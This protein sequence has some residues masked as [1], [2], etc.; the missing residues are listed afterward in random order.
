MSQIH[1][2][3]PRTRSEPLLELNS[4]LNASHGQRHLHE[5]TR[6]M[7]VLVLFHFIAAITIHL[8]AMNKVSNLVLLIWQ[9]TVLLSGGNFLYIFLNW[10]SGN[11]KTQIIQLP[12][13]QIFIASVFLAVVWSVPLI[14][15]SR[16]IFDDSNII[17]FGIVMAM[18]AMGIVTMLRVPMSAIAYISFLSVVIS[19]YLFSTLHEHKMLGTVICLIAGVALV[20][21]IIVLHNDVKHTAQIEAANRR[22]N[23]TIKLLLNDFEQETKDWIW[24]IDQHFMLTSHSP[25]LTSIFELTPDALLKDNFLSVLATIAEKTDVAKLSDEIAK[26]CNIV[27]FILETNQNNI[28]LYWKISARAKF[29]LEDNFLGYDGVSRDITEQHKSEIEIRAAKD[30][31]ERASMA[32][33]QFLAV[34]SHELRTPINSIVGFS[35]ILNAGQN[36][37]ISAANRKAY[38]DTILD[39]SKQ[40]QALINDILDATRFERG[41]MNIIDQDIDAAEL[42]EVSTKICRDQAVK[43]DI[44]IVVRVQ[45]DVNL[46]GDLTRLKQV[47]V[48][49]LTNAIK[50]SPPKT[51]I[52][53]DM[54]RDAGDQ[55]I[56]AIR[57]SGIGITAEDAERLFEPFVQLDEGNTRRF[58]GVGLGLSIARR[59]ARLHGGDVTLQGTEE[60]GTEARL[61]IPAARLRWPN[62]KLAPRVNVAA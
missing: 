62:S 32:K 37:N 44:S 3:Q 21:M 45:E 28:Q 1:S 39:S 46:M 38:L 57:D 17:V 48:N 14:V 52:N 59:I 26:R 60:L 24:E 36:E 43:S 25:N 40:L 22:Q 27:D 13:R 20:V 42:I 23:Q 56:I 16:F 58:G 50:F 35:E 18:M 41:A 55:L 49:L 11:A 9:T 6:T 33:S 2:H 34:I 5:A 10:K 53:I 19:N 29:D 61:I 12:E 4:D 51:V 8:L 31:A 7:P 30:S 15:F 47:L 54:K